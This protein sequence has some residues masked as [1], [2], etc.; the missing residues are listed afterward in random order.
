LIGA[1][2]L[3]VFVLSCSAVGLRL[4]WIGN[5][6][7][8]G[9]AWSCGNGFLFIALIGQPL[10]VVSGLP[11]ATVGDLNHGMAAAAMLAMAAGLSSFYAFTLTVFRPRAPWAWALTIAAILA[12]GIGSFARIGALALADRAVLAHAVAPRWMI[13]LSTLSVLCYGWLGLESMLEWSKSRRRLALG[14]ADPVVSNRFLMWGLFGTST[15]LLSAFMLWL[16][17]TTADG[18]QGPVG[19]I[20]LTGFGLVSA[21]TVMLAFFPPARYVAWVRKRAAQLEG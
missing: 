4:V 1:I 21:G 11:T 5:K 6:D 19:Q 17:L 13:S 15:T 16:Q 20:A 12:L 7:G 18:A 9:P 3:A 14:L 10:S 2:A 8:L